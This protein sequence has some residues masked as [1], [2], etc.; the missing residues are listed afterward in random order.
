MRESSADPIRR[1]FS[2]PVTYTDIVRSEKTDQ[3]RERRE[4]R[5]EGGGQRESIGKGFGTQITAAKLQL[6]GGKSSIATLR[7]ELNKKKPFW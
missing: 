2:N 7:N 1:I 5:E 6:C 3:N 4:E